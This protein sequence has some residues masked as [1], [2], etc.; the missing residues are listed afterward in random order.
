MS[1]STQVHEDEVPIDGGNL[2]QGVVRIGDTVRRPHTASS[3][4]TAK[5]L[6]HL[7]DVGFDGVPRFIG[8]DDKGRDT[9]S[10]IPGETKW[11]PLTDPQVIAGGQLLRA[12][13]D[14]TRGTEL[15]GE[16]P[17]V[18]HGDPGPNNAIFQND[19]PAAWIDF[20]LVA[21]GDPMQDLGWMAWFWC[22]SMKP[23][24]GPVEK[25]ARQVRLLLAA[26]GLEAH[27]R[28]AVIESIYE[29]MAW[30]V[31]F[32]EGKREQDVSPH[33]KVLPP[34]KID[35]IIEHTRLERA[36]VE[37]HLDVFLGEPD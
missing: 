5:L 14:A 28:S 25:Q 26:Y 21:P 4:F 7:E 31:R 34:E 9:L 16:H 2:T 12:F 17:V 11:R 8:T 27:Q 36:Y 24:R 33:Q 15:A 19:V 1:V 23:E 30:N 6:R 10:V 29:R 3:D 32:F 20:D 35:L 18:C 13:H 22:I 37:A